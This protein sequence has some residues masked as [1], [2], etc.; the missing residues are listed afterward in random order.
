[1]NGS[2]KQFQRAIPLAKM[3]ARPR[4][5]KRP[6]SGMSACA[7]SAFTLIELLIV[8]AII[9]ILAAILLPALA[10]AKLKATQ[11]VCLSN[12]KQLG[13]AF[14]MYAADNSD[15]IV[16]MDGRFGNIINRAGGYWG[17]P[18]GPNYPGNATTAEQL[19]AMAK[20]QLTTNNP[21]YRYASNPTVYECPGDARCKK[22]SKA[23]GWSY[24]SYSKTQNVGGEP[25][26][27]YWGAGD[28]YRTLTAIR[29]PSDTF[30][31][32][33]DASSENYGFN[34]GTWVV[35]WTGNRLTPFT[36]TDPPA[37]F[38]GNVGTF[39]F[40]DG[41]A[42]GH[43]WVGGGLIAAGTLEANGQQPPANWTAGSSRLDTA[44]IAQNYRFPGW[45]LQ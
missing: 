16:P 42:E 26:A 2:L 21:L 3:G 24:G 13:L 28:T 5:T 11:A 37:M 29:F 7:A 4:V 1:M 8:I 30:A 41:H 36:Y 31:F 10:R 6:Q 32:I 12:Q 33:E 14:T 45:N 22:P 19:D 25:Y 35:N 9:A 40:T 23:L 17:G 34:P 44:Y 18:G 15:Q 38:H 39:A 20:A 43:K 27:N